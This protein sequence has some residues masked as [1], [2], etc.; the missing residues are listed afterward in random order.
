[1]INRAAKGGTIEIREAT[2]RQ[3]LSLEKKHEEKSSEATGHVKLP[4]LVITAFDGRREMW[5]SFWNTFVAEV[6]SANISPVTKFSYLKKYVEPK[7][8]LFIDGLPV[9]SKGYERAKNI[10]KTE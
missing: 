4:K 3:K 8:R 7:V 9:T 5:L 1:M 10:L 2:T 6:D